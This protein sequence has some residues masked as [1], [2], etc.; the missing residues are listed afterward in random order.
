MGQ[1]ASNTASVYFEDMVVPDEV[2]TH[3]YML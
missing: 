2:S 1:R 3:S